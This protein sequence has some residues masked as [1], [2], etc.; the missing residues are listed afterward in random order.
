MCGIDRNLRH[1]LIAGSHIVRNRGYSASVGDGSWTDGL[2]R[3]PESP[4]EMQQSG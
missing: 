3:L 4:A 2:S 1:C